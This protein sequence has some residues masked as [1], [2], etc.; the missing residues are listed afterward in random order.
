MGLRL[1]A[2]VRGAPAV[3][4]IG[5]SQACAEALHCTSPATP[6]AIVQFKTNPN[7]LLVAP[8][9]DSR[10]I[11][12]MVRDLA[13]TDAALAPD[14]VHLAQ[15]AIPRYQTAIAAG[16]AQAAIACTNVDQQAGL[17]IQQAVAAFQDG[18]FQASFEA[19]AGD[20][21][22][23]ATNAAASSA[24]SSAGSVIVVNS[25]TG[26]RATTNGG[27]GGGGNLAIVQITSPGITANGVDSNSGEQATT[28]GGGGNL[29]IEQ[30][31]STGTAN[32]GDQ[33][34]SPSTLAANPVS[35]TR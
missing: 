9:S 2:G 1:V 25:N 18:Q 14:L 16:L 24:A 3:L 22:T 28:N 13:G 29:A 7:A 31:T 5:L 20:L 30:I 10:T 19:V 32:G 12:A 6:E 26:A 15:G 23:A 27:G 17:S 4:V 33:T 11:E 35:A 8:D 21:S 34:T